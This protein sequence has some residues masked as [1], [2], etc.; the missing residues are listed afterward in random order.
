VAGCG[1]GGAAFCGLPPPT[2]SDF[3]GGG[4]AQVFVC[5]EATACMRK[6]CRKNAPTT[7]TLAE[8]VGMEWG[9][10]ESTELGR[11]ASS[12]GL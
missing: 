6:G 11:D 2:P 5:A 7:M 8:L 1:L 9:E 12:I 10:V 4:G 3:V